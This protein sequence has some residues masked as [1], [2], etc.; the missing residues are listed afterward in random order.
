[1]DILLVDRKVII[2]DGQDGVGEHGQR[3]GHGHD[4]S[5]LGNVIVGSLSNCSPF[6]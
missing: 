2:I 5:K 6:M 1:M 4:P 3:H